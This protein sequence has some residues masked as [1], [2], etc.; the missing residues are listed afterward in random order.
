MALHAR[1]QAHRDSVPRQRH[2]VLHRRGRRRAARA[3][4]ALHAGTHHRRPGHVQPPV[5]AARRRDGVP[6]HH[7]G[8]PCVARQLRLADD[9]RREGRRVPAAQPPQLLDLRPRLVLRDLLAHQRCSRHRVD[10]LHALQHD[11]EWRRHRDGSRRLHRRI[12]VDPHR[13]QFHH[14]DPQAPRAG[15]HVVAAAALSA[16]RST[17]RASSRFSRRPSSPS[18]CSF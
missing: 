12:L 17:R 1:P 16:G 8:H 4:R 15:P 11:D 14:H 18:P 13:R 7:P 3:H 10:L 9:A 2:Y 6:L 5:H